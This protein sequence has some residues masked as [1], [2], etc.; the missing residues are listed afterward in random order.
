MREPD[1]HVKKSRA[2]RTVDGGASIDGSKS[3]R[4]ASVRYIEEIPSRSHLS[5]NE[6]D[7][8]RKRR[9]LD[10]RFR[11][12]SGDETVPSAIYRGG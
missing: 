3:F 12:Q 11:R 10:E 5:P 6:E 4:K 9:L 7:G 2:H 1:V 8:K